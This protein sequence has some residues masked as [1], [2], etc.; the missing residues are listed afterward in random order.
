MKAC[1]KKS[2]VTDGCFTVPRS[3]DMQLA[4]QLEASQTVDNSP[5]ILDEADN[6]EIIK[7]LGFASDVDSNENNH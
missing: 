2:F 1:I 3:D 6:K 4:T 7:G 5:A